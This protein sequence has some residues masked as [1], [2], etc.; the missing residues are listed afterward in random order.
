MQN[1]IFHYIW[2]C[3]FLG[4]GVTGAGI[5]GLGID[6]S[7]AELAKIYIDMCFGGAMMLITYRR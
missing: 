1:K 3:G 6:N 4:V 2:I 5:L 7:F